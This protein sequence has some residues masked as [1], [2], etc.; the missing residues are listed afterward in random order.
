MGMGGW[1]ACAVLHN[2]YPV[3][4]QGIHMYVYAGGYVDADSVTFTITDKAIYS[5]KRK[6]F[7]IHEGL[8]SFSHSYW[9]YTNGARVNISVKYILLF[10][11]V[12]FSSN[13]SYIVGNNLS[14]KT[15]YHPLSAHPSLFW[16]VALRPSPAY[17]RS[18]I[19][20]TWIDIIK[21]AEKPLKLQYRWI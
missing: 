5:W 13:T 12:F 3:R 16:S 19:L 10:F 6:C 20:T 11:F 14:A 8:F 17:T 21:Q 9:C 15:R 2:I 7:D 4:I 1:G 18:E